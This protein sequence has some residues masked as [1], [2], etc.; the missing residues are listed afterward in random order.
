MSLVS[1]LSNP[2][3]PI[4][5]SDLSYAGPGFLLSNL[6]TY[7]K[8]LIIIIDT[9]GC[10]EES[11]NINTDYFNRC[12]QVLEGAFEQLQKQDSHN[13]AYDIY[14]SA[15]VKEFEIVLELAGKLLK[16]R[17]AHYFATNKAVDALSFRDVFRYAVKHT[18]ITVEVCERWIK[19]RDNRNSTAH[20]YGKEFAEQTLKL[21]P[22]FILDAN[23]LS[24]IIGDNQ[25]QED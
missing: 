21:L 16:K 20:D 3:L 15:C 5:A 14:R 18:L 13:I 12:I 4:K 24:K 8:R 23:G 22:D 2:H 11:M 17:L 6:K 9:K 1:S 19:Y 7:T 25:N 10:E